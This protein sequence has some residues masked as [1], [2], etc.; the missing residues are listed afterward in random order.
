MTIRNPD[1]WGTDRDLLR[2]VAVTIPLTSWL[3]HCFP[4]AS[5]NCPTSL[6][7]F[8]HCTSPTPG[9]Q[10]NLGKLHNLPRSRPWLQEAGG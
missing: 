2:G 7:L 9:E 3:G 10:S 8:L 5:S 1:C 6:S 4:D